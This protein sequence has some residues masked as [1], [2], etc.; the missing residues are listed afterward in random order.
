MDYAYCEMQNGELDK[1]TRNVDSARQAIDRAAAKPVEVWEGA[2]RR[3]PTARERLLTEL[4]IGALRSRIDEFAK[5]LADAQ[6][7]AKEL[8]ELFHTLEWFESGDYGADQVQSFAREWVEA[9]LASSA[10][11]GCGRAVR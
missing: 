1:A 10:P 11:P 6:R 3:E 4:G 7:Q 2:T 8:S 5:T 9:Q